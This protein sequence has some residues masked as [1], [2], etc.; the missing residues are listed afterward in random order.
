MNHYTYFDAAAVPAP[1]DPTV[2]IGGLPKKL[3]FQTEAESLLTADK[4]FTAITG[5]DPVRKST[6]HVKFERA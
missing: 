5:T 3:L 1:G 4:T 6:I 2:V